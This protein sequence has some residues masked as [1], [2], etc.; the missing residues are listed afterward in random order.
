MKYIMEKE[1]RTR[2]IKAKERKDLFADAVIKDFFF[3][4]CRKTIYSEFTIKPKRNNNYEWI[5]KYS[6]PP[7]P[8]NP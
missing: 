6:I 5:W 2:K 4:K 8:I 7:T 1:G 3:P